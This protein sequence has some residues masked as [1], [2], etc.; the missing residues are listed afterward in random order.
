MSTGNPEQ[1]ADYERPCRPPKR[2]VRDLLVKLMR[3]RHWSHKTPRDGL[4][5]RIFDLVSEHHRWWDWGHRLMILTGSDDGGNWGEPEPPTWFYRLGPP[6]RM[7]R[8]KYPRHPLSTFEI[9]TTYDEFTHRTKGFNEDQMYEWKAIC[10]NQDGD[11]ILGHR[12]WGGSFYGMPQCEVALLRRYLRMWRRLDWFGAR[13]WLYS[14]G[15]HAAINQKVP[16]TCQVSPPP[17]SGGYSHWFCDQKRKHT[18]PHRYRN[19]VWDPTKKHVEY[20]PEGS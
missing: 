3:K 10:T 14:Q 5:R 1:I 20:A 17:G 15:L 16:R 11:L 8:T 13:S 2:P 7:A 18:G 19:Y 6:K 9:I 12:F 4:R